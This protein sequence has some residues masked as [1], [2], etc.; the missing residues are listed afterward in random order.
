[1]GDCRLR[2][3]VPAQSARRRRRQSR[4]GA[5]E[6]P[7]AGEGRTQV[8]DTHVLTTVDTEDIGRLQRLGTY[9]ALA[10]LIVGGLGVAFQ[11]AQFMPSW[12]I[13]F[14]FCTGLSLGSLALLMVQH[15]TSGSWGLV[16]RPHFG[17]GGPLVPLLRPAVRP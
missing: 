14:T 6:A 11:P 2:P 3:R 12:L 10:G 7:A 15:M 17:A 9:G 4:G 8:M 5:S 1:M 13:G 16:T